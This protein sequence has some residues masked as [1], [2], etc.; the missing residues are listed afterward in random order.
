MYIYI[1]SICMV[2]YRVSMWKHPSGNMR[3]WPLSIIQSKQ[4]FGSEPSVQPQE[5]I[6]FPSKY[7]AF[8]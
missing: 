3:E 7:G 5:T 4:M 1:Y 2:S 6:D 8:L